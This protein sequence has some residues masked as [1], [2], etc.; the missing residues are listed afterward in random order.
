MELAV[1]GTEFSTRADTQ[2]CGIMP[3]GSALQSRSVS[4]SYAGLIT[5]LTVFLLGLVLWRMP[6]SQYHVRA[7]YAVAFGSQRPSVEKIEQAFLSRQAIRLAL[8]HAGQ[9]VRG[10][11]S[12]YI[13]EAEVDALL[14]ILKMDLRR[15]SHDELEIQLDLTA[16]HEQ[17]CQEVVQQIGHHFLRSAWNDGSSDVARPLDASLQARLREARLYEEK[18]RAD[19]EHQIDHLIR[20]VGEATELP[21]T[22]PVQ[23][24]SGETV[25]NPAWSDL[26][27]ELE[28]AEL[29][30]Q[31]LASRSADSPERVRLEQR[32]Q[33]ISTQL[34]AT[35]KFVTQVAKAA[36][37][38]GVTPPL[39]IATARAA[40]QES[41]DKYQELKS[42]YSR[43]QQRRKELE[44]EWLASLT[45]AGP[46]A[47]PSGPLKW[48]V[49]PAAVVG[50]V[51]GRPNPTQFLI[52]SMLA[53]AVGLG[54]WQ[55][56]GRLRSTGLI[57]STLDLRKHSP[58]PV[59]GQVVSSQ[60]MDT[61]SLAENRTRKQLALRCLVTVAEVTL[62]VLATLFTLS[63]LTAS[64][65]VDSLITDPLG[66][67]IDGLQPWLPAS[68]SKVEAGI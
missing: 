8:Q 21:E 66:T 13:S 61:A 54:S 41:R 25:E 26:Q 17:W 60:A 52:T 36:T 10:G 48:L 62:V 12:I 6:V 56:A 37:A 19:L 33:A 7:T 23:P 53:V 45:T 32:I 27:L 39:V 22:S 9:V 24:A 1:Q 42:A 58:V 47:A 28:T 51:G 44:A 68:G 11:D 18:A 49:E 30:Q 20:V 15:V 3:T 34:Q 35:P 4:R 50:K 46:V 65:V 55:F 5:G 43:A 38:S 2:G 57:E 14:R 16:P 67:F 31:L 29:Q 40:V 59:L 64:P 63:A